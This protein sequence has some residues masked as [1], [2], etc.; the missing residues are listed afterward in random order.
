M[1]RIQAYVLPVGAVGRMLDKRWDFGCGGDIVEVD[2]FGEKSTAG[3]R[4]LSC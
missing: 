2:I 1:R 4:Q 3:L